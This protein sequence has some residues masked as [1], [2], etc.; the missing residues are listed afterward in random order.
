MYESLIPIAMADDHVMI[1]QALAGLVESFGYY[2]VIIQASNGKDLLQKLMPGN[3]PA[4]V[5][6]DI[7]MPEMGG[8]KL[9]KLFRP[10]TPK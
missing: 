8:M 4:L 10:N 5:L 6:L 7:S 2:K 3:L 1:R 9:L